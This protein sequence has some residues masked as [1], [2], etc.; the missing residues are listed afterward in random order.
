MVVDDPGL[1]RQIREAAEEEER[2]SYENRFPP[3]WLKALAHLGTTWQKPHL[4]DAPYLV[5]VFKGNIYTSDLHSGL[6]VAKLVR[7]EPLVP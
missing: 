1:K 7:P 6:W 3:A 5:V 2:E 4:E